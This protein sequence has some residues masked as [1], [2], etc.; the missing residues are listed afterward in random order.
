MIQWL[1][2]VVAVGLGVVALLRLRKPHGGG[3][4]ATRTRT[5]IV[6][7]GTASAPA[8]VRQP[9][10][11]AARRGE[12]LVWDISNTSGAPQEI[13][14]RGFKDQHNP[15]APQPVEKNDSD[16][17]VRIDQ[18]GEIRD[19]VRGQ[20]RGGTYKYDIWLNSALAVDPEV[21]IYES[22]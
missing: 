13:S 17:T 10:R 18:N 9:E 6:I 12:E 19:R 3:G 21:V 7:G 8:I 20:A 2:V 15:G 11:L 14:L 5:T 16:R 1:G 22:V 4:Y